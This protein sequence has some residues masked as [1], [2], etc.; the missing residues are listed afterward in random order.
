M[1]VNLRVISL[2][3]TTATAEQ[4]Y[5]F[6]RPATVITGPIGTGKSSLLMLFKHALGGSAMLTPA[7]REN[8]LSVQAE[9]VAGGEHVVL[10]PVVVKSNETFAVL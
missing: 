9:V 1:A 6:N 4:T 10:R 8:V 5:R 7:V 2:T 3:V